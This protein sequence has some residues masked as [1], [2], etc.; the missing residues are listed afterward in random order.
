[1][2]ITYT[3]ASI[4]S[5]RIIAKVLDL[6]KYQATP[7]P[8]HK[9]AD[10]I[11]EPHAATRKA[12][13][14]ASSEGLI[15]NRQ[16]VGGQLTPLSAAIGRF[17]S[18]QGVKEEVC[19]LYRRSAKPFLWEDQEIHSLF[20]SLERDGSYFGLVLDRG[21]VFGV[22]AVSPLSQAPATT[23]MRHTHSPLSPDTLERWGFDPSDALFVDHLT[24][25]PCYRGTDL[26]VDLLS[27]VL[28]RDQTIVSRVD[29][30]DVRS[31]QVFEEAGFDLPEQKPVKVVRRTATGGSTSVRQIYF[32]RSPVVATPDPLPWMTGNWWQ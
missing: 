25:A 30:D 21:E 11:G 9:V 26:G 23:S 5:G 29:S 18:L 32:V 19:E 7:L 8:S 24:I 28:P 20:S 10:F 13:E 3:L 2:N 16:R 15:F 22:V 4:N 6:L 1:M 27:E 17:T 31:R 12:M 14:I